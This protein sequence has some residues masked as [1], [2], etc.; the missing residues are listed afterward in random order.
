MMDVVLEQ[1]REHILDPLW[2]LEVARL[3]Q[4]HDV[5]EPRRREL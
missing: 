5:V 1:V 2:V 3:V 4:G